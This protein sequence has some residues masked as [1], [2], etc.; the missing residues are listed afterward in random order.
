MKHDLQQQVTTLLSTV[1]PGDSVS[2]IDSIVGEFFSKPS[3][4]LIYI[5]IAL[6]LFTT[7]GGIKA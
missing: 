6:L 7:M 3:P 2:F 5:N 1:I 4:G